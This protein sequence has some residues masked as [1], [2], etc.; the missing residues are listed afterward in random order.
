MG[1]TASRDYIKQTSTI[2]PA[3]PEKPIYQL[4]ESKVFGGGVHAPN[5]QDNRGHTSKM[6]ESK[7]E[8]HWLIKSTKINSFICLS[9]KNQSQVQLL[10]FQK[11]IRF[12]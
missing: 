8:A 2:L 10:T 7:H 4:F 5:F 9:S 3:L 1:G 12:L 11:K 6:N